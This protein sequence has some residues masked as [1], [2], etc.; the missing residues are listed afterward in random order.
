MFTVAFMK[1][2]LTSAM[3]VSVAFLF[4]IGSVPLV[5]ASTV[6]GASVAATPSGLSVAA[7]T[8]VPVTLS[9]IP[10]IV[11]LGTTGCSYAYCGSST[12][13]ID[14]KGTTSY[15]FTGCVFDYKLDTSSEYTEGVCGLASSLTIAAGQ[16]T[17]ITWSTGFNTA[18]AYN[19]KVYLTSSSQKSGTGKYTVIAP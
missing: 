4:A 7:L 16:T 2:I 9:F 5:F 15:T 14:N 13:K 3:I 8:K 11:D 6:T 1:I 10:K 18:G 12:L 19:I 17:N